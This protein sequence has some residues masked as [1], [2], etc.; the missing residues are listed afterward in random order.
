MTSVVAKS[1]FKEISNSGDGGV[2]RVTGKNLNIT[3]CVFESTFCTNQ[4]GSLFLSNCKLNINRTTFLK[5]YTS[6]YTNNI[7]GNSIYINQNS[8]TLEY[9]STYLCAPSAK[10]CSDSSICVETCV[11]KIKFYNS[12]NNYGISGA[13]AAR[14]TY[15]IDGSDVRYINSDASNDLLAFEVQKNPLTIYNTNVVNIT[16]ANRYIYWTDANNVIAFNGCIFWDCTVTRFAYSNTQ[17]TF[18]NC[19]SNSITGISTTTEKKLNE[20]TFAIICTDKKIIKT[21]HTC[22]TSHTYVI[23][24]LLFLIS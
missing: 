14:I 20:I 13:S 24:S 21:Y 8:A 17:C 2:F 4:G 11:T 9:I 6:A 16:S 15:S 22:K 1:I 10:P 19:Y 3:C 7:C 5:C 18:T 12:S 23:F